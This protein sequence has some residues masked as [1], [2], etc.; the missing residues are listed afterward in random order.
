MRRGYGFTLIE[1]LVTIAVIALL[2]GL[3]LPALG[4]VRESARTAACLSNQRQLLIAWAAYAGD[5]GVWPWGRDREGERGLEDAEK[6][7]AGVLSHAWGGVHWFGREADGTPIEVENTVGSVLPAER[8]L[9]SYVSNGNSV[10]EGDAEAFRCPS[11]RPLN[12]KLWESFPPQIQPQEEWWDAEALRLSSSSLADRTQYGKL[13][14]SYATY[15]SLYWQR[16]FDPDS[17]AS[18]KRFTT[19]RSTWGPDDVRIETSRVLLLLDFG[20]QDTAR[21]LR[22]R[23]SIEDWP[24]AMRYGF[25]HGEGRASMGFLD[26]SARLEEIYSPGGDGY[27]YWEN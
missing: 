9:N 19:I 24:G 23:A 12:Y 2:I 15:R 13:G 6:N 11:D 26:G 25:W 17:T 1:L 21:L 22:G 20:D 8:P 16:E 10:L 5:S 14:S 27:V 7:Y 3:L 4:R 18:D